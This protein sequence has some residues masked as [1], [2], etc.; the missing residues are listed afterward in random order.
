MG[1]SGPST[2]I[3]ALS[4]P[5]PHN[6]ATRCSTVPMRAEAFGIPQHRA[7]PG[8]DHGVEACRD[9]AV[10]VGAPEHDAVVD[11]GR[12]DRQVNPLPAMDANTH[13]VDRCFQRALPPAEGGVL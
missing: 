5:R 13:T 7:Q 9:R 2:S 4:M 10:Q 3:R 12:P 6:A 11:R 8:V 1:I